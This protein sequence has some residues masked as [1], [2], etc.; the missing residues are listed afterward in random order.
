VTAKLP[1]SGAP[2]EALRKKG[3]F[4]TPAWVAEAMI[5]FVAH[6]ANRL[7]DA[8]FGL[9]AFALAAQSLLGKSLPRYVGCDTDATIWTRAPLHGVSETVMQGIENRDFFSYES[10]PDGTSIV[11]NPPYIRHHRVS[12][13]QKAA[14]QR[15]AMKNTGY[16]L[17]GRT[18]LHAFFLIHALSLLPKGQRL[19]FIVPADICEGIY[20]RKLWTWI[21]KT[22][23]V[24][25]V[26][27]FAA[28]ATPFPGIDTNALILLLSAEPPTSSYLVARVK[29]A[30]TR[31]LAKWIRGDL[32]AKQFT[33]IEIE[34]RSI[35]DGVAHGM[36][37][38][39]LT[40]HSTSGMT[41]GDVIRVM[42][43]IATGANEFF[44]LT[45]EQ[46]REH[47]LPLRY[48]V[49]AVGRTRDV[50]GSE[51]SDADLDSLDKEGRPTFLLS[52][53]GEPRETF[54]PSVQQYL[55]TGEELAL[56][57]RA[58]IKMRSAW[59]KMETREVPD[60]LFAYLGRRNIRFVANNARVVPLTSFLCV[61]NRH[62]K[63]VSNEQLRALFDDAD[64]VG[65]MSFV[66]KSYGGGAIKLEPRSL[67][68][69]PIVE[70][71][72]K[73]HPWLESIK[74]STGK[75]LL[76]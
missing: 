31:D 6:G 75:L 42:R 5:A 20:S 53:N 44:F 30:E 3:Q 48:F 27:G 33:A 32:Q 34:A 65:A 46:V 71:V 60:F 26:I 67:E 13:E 4:F 37:R 2:R 25:A 1:A 51:I 9:G 69:V 8:G 19:A 68:R 23:R 64:L 12:A 11:S 10:L 52:L 38:F 16:T 66:A 54:A 41:L 40:G 24:H 36:S 61:Y 56:A 50:Q 22:F 49:R 58:L 63:Q 76:L 29:D 62:P 28:D 14:F 59:Y 70:A 17:D 73:R 21:S 15:L 7:F 72:M 47:K 18:G 45:S 43:G 39:A 74:E 55:K 35:S 57:D